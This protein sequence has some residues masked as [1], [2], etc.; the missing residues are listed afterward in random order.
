MSDKQPRLENWFIG[1]DDTLFGEAY[2]HPNILDG[3]MVCTSRVV[4]FD[5]V[6]KIAR[7]KN[8]N[9]ELGKPLGPLWALSIK[10]PRNE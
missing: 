7:T 10:E 8:T 1:Q 6:A 2:N 9:Y 5:P 4:E 3:E